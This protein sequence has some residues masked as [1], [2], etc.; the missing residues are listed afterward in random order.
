MST[1]TTE[2]PARTLRPVAK[3][4]RDYGAIAPRSGAPPAFAV[5]PMLNKRERQLMLAMLAQVDDTGAAIPLNRATL[6]TSGNK[7]QEMYY[8]GWVM[9]AGTP[10]E[11]GSGNTPES[12][13]WWLTTYG[14]QIARAIGKQVAA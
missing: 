5:T 6:R 10:D 11:R 7:M 13:W 14:E 1:T 4:Q 12:S 3:D 8:A 2:R 9:G